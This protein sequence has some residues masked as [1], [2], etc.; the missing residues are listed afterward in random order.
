MK[1]MPDH[2]RPPPLADP[3]TLPTGTK[4]LIF[5]VMAFGYGGV[6]SYSA[7]LAIENHVTPTAVYLSTLAA[8]IVVVRVS[9]TALPCLRAS[10]APFANVSDVRVIHQIAISSISV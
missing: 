1:D 10:A 9:T 2:G 6:T 4:F 3:S 8:E 5:T 7:I